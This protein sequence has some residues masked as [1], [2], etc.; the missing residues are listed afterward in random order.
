MATNWA[1]PSDISMFPFGYKSKLKAKRPITPHLKFSTC[2]QHGNQ[3]PRI[4]ANK[5]R[6]RILFVLAVS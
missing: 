2:M 3:M 4:S 6:D 1:F 5:Q